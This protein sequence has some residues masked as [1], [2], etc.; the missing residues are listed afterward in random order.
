MTENLTYEF[1][2]FQDVQEFRRLRGENPELCA[3]F[4]QARA[5]NIQN[6]LAGKGMGTRHTGEADDKYQLWKVS[7]VFCFCL[8]PSQPPGPGPCRHTAAAPLHEFGLICIN[9]HYLCIGSA[10]VHINFASHLISLH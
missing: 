3:V 4:D 5:A 10:S 2:A 6:D 9:L 1:K 8:P 7:L